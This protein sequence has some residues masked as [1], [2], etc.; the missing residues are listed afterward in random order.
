MFPA[1]TLASFPTYYLDAAV[2]IQE[3]LLPVTSD[4][5][6]G[7]T[8]TTVECTPRQLFLTPG[9]N[10]YELNNQHP[11]H[12]MLGFADVAPGHTAYVVVAEYTVDDGFD[13]ESKWCVPAITTTKAAA[14]NAKQACDRQQNTL[15]WPWTSPDDYQQAHIY[16]VVVK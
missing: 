3:E 7:Y 12:G 10:R 5:G 14:Q 15:D 6:W 2:D 1:P 4:G 13:R 11:G 9:D 8:A 16:P